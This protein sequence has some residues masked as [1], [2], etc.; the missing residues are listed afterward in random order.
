[1]PG[2]LSTDPN[3][4]TAYTGQP[5]PGFT[6]VVGPSYGAQTPSQ[7]AQGQQ[8]VYTKQPV[9]GTSPVMGPSYASTPTGTNLAGLAAQGAR[10]G[11]NPVARVGEQRYFNGQPATWDGTGWRVG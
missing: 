2:Y 4:G 11:T 8:P 5:V 3:A 9:P 7:P 6:P 10:S 1:M